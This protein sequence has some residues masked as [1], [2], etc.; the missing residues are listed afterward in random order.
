MTSFSVTFSNVLLT[1]L[2]LLPG[3][4]LQKYRKT[5]AE[6]LSSF[7]VVLL[8]VCGPGMFLNALISLDYAPEMLARI[9]LFLVFSCIRQEKAPA[10][11]TSV[12]KLSYGMYLMHMFFMVPI[13]TWIIGGDPASP[14]IPVWLAIPSI[15]ILTYLC[16]MVTTKLIS[17]IPGSKWVV[18]C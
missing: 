15:A 6:H 10:A 8:Y 3:F 2:Y 7:S 11:V 12:A 13:A 16:C 9:G 18:G 14:S 5:R 1:L 17:L 4:L